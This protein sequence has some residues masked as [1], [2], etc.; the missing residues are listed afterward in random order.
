MIRCH[1]NELAQVEA[2]LFKQEWDTVDEI[3]FVDGWR[4][5]I[6]ETGHCYYYHTEKHGDKYVVVT[7]F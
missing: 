3:P 7:S 2:L 5:E 1:E 6:I 4:V